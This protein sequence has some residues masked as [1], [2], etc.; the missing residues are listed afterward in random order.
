MRWETFESGEALA[1]RAAQF[2]L[3]TIRDDPRTVLG[4]PTG[5]T[6]IGMYERVVRECERAYHCFRDVTTFNLDE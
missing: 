6:P 5:R 2:L 4:L 3:G 1:E